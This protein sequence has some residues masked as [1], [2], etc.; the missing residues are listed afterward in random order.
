MKNTVVSRPVA[1][2]IATKKDNAEKKDVA[3]VLS[4]ENSSLAED[5]PR[6]IADL[7]RSDS[8]KKTAAQVDADG[9]LLPRSNSK[10]KNK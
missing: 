8:D 1:A 9:V 4:R 7:I 3:P 2:A 5:S 6:S 10:N